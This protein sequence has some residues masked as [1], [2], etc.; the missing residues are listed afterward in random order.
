MG[1]RAAHVA[2]AFVFV[3]CVGSTSAPP[4]KA[5]PTLLPT[6]ADILQQ[7][8]V[9]VPEQRPFRVLRFSSAL[10]VITQGI[11]TASGAVV[12]F[13]A[14]SGRRGRLL[15]LDFGPGEVAY[16]FGSVWIARARG[17]GPLLRVDPLTLAI[18]AQVGRDQLL[19]PGVAIGFGAVWTANQD[20]FAPPGPG[21][22]S[23]S[24]ID[25]STNRIVAT[26]PSGPSPLT[27]SAGEGGLWTANHGN[28]SV[29]RVDP[30]SHQVVATVA[31]EG[32]HNVVAAAGSA[33]VA[34]YH[35]RALL[36]ISV[37]GNRVTTRVPLP[38]APQAMTTSS[39]DLWVASAGYGVLR[40]P[41][42]AVT[43]FALA[44]GM[45]RRTIAVGA[46][47]QGV[48]WGEGELWVVCDEPPVA[49]R[50]RT[51]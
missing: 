4:Q 34:S 12:R 10:I 15:Q 1:A 24:R 45:L 46:A 26:V 19:G 28:E 33:W 17:D 42:G 3:A 13:D 47:I 9:D 20:P 38:F 44:S 31:A 27:I 50:L 40:E 41:A 43:G 8:P 2:L 25:P 39:T 37:S 16:G 32:I 14:R 48:T 23:V 7:L 21:S 49:L 18:V 36:V 11:T 51:D 5:A 35:T 6:T 30:A 29:S 22:G